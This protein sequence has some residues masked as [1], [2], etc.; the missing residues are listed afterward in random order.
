MPGYGRKQDEE[1]YCAIQDWITDALEELSEIESGRYDPHHAAS[2]GDMRA[3]FWRRTRLLVSFLGA[4]FPKID[5]TPLRQIYR[6]ASTLHALGHG[7]RQPPTHVLSALLD[8]AVIALSVL[9]RDILDRFIYE[10]PKQKGRGAAT[11][12]ETAESPKAPC[13]TTNEKRLGREYEARSPSVKRSAF[14]KSMGMSEEHLRYVLQK[15]RADRKIR[16]SK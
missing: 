5:P 3:G 16:Q 11:P 10:D 9:E 8:D 14:A 15:V 2:P 7:A 12:G 1:I 6:A 4:R 13:P